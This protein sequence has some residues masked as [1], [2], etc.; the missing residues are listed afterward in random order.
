MFSEEKTF[1]IIAG[2]NGA[3]KTTASFTVLPKILS[4]K[5]F[6]NADEIAKGISP[7]NTDGVALLAGKLMLKR[8][9]GLMT[10]GET[11]SVETTLASKLFV[12]TIRKAKE[13]NYLTV[14]LFFWLRNIETAKNRVKQRVK[15]GGH[16]IDP[17]VIERRY[18]SGIKNLFE[19]YVPVVD[20]LSIFD[21]TD[22]NL[23]CIAEK[24][25]TDEQIQVINEEK[26][27]MLEG[28]YET[29]K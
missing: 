2:C 27:R 19:L 28:Y 24:S 18:K 16:N 9:N 6:V 21:N 23:E 17:Y 10:K 3:G 22:N 20:M 1:Y 15:S 14:L 4:C 25:G 8:M 26:Y 12:E 11:F 29:I 13:E 7:F 5:E